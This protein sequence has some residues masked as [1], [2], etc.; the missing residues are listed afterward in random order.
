MRTTLAVLLVIALAA[1]TP[2]VPDSCA[3]GNAN[4][5]HDNTHPT[6][7][8][9]H[10]HARA[11]SYAARLIHCPQE[12]RLRLMSVGAQC[13]FVALVQEARLLCWKTGQVKLG[14]IGAQCTRSCHLPSGCAC[15]IVAAPH[16]RARRWLR[17]C[18]PY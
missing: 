3:N 1:C 8:N 17:T 12:H 6:N 18:M 13:P 4:P 2:A 14:R 9:P 5:A 10:E 16:I 15:M 7:R 11:N